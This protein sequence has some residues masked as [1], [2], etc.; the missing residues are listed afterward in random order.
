[1]K[2]LFIQVHLDHGGSHPLPSLPDKHSWQPW[3]QDEKS[4][5]EETVTIAAHRGLRVAGH[6]ARGGGHPKI[7]VRVFH[8]TERDWRGNT[9][10]RCQFTDFKFTRK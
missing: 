7:L 10:L 8:N 1:M 3:K 4:N 2:S 5:R 6:M 9:P